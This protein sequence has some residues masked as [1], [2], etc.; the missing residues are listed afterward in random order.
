MKT[1]KT[2]YEWIDGQT[3]TPYSIEIWNASRDN[4]PIK[5]CGYYLKNNYWY[6]SCT[7]SLSAKNDYCGKCGGETFVKQTVEQK[8]EVVKQQLVA[9]KKERDAKVS[10][11]LAELQ[12][13]TEKHCRSEKALDYHIECEKDVE[14][15]LEKMTVEFTALKKKEL[16]WGTATDELEEVTTYLAESDQKLEAMTKERDVQI[17]NNKAIT[18]ELS[19]VTRE[20]NR[21]CSRD[22]FMS[23]KVNDLQS[24]LNTAEKH[25]SELVSIDGAAAS[26]HNASILVS[27]YIKRNGLDK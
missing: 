21:L 18:E 10:N 6:A 13:M 24:D 9:T 23:M 3:K 4:I 22:T 27:A 14:Q 8:L 19:A 7:D 5:T 15:K 17:A 16:M 11:V 26:R 1:V 12:T 25:L 2:F 20:R